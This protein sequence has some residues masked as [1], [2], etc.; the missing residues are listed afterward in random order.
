MSPKSPIA[1]KDFSYTS[2]D[3]VVFTREQLSIPG[4]EMFG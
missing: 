1:M 3:Q 2:K 4:I